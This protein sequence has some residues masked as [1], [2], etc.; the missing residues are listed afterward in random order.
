VILCLQQ[1]LLQN[2]CGYFDIQTLP[3]SSITI[4]VAAQYSIQLIQQV[5][6]RIYP[7]TLLPLRHLITLLAVSRIFT[8][9]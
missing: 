8:G 6:A 9:H 3:E 7:S 5:A 2:N 1:P 4:P